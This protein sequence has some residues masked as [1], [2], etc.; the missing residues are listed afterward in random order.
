[1]R[2][3]ADLH[4]HSYLSRACSRELRPERLHAWCQLKGIGV[5]AT[6]D[7]THPKWLEELREK[8]APAEPGLYR[9]KAPLAKAADAEV[10]SACRAPVRFLLEA[11]LSCIYK[12][13]GRVRKVHNLVY[14]PS[15]QDASRIAARLEKIGN[16]RSDGRP[17]LGLDSRDLFA[18]VLECCEEAVLVPA[19]AWTPH[20]SVFGSESGFDSLEECFG[21][22]TPRVFALET[23][24]SSDPPMNW[25]VSALDRLALMSNSD[26]HSPEKLGREANRFDTEPSFAGIFDAVRSRD[27]ERFLGTLEFF[28]EE[29]KYHVDGHRACK[30]RLTPAE[31]LER[32]GLCPA[33]GKPVTVGVLHRVEKLADREEGFRP[34]GAS[35]YENLV[36]LKEILSETLDCGAATST[37][38]REYRRLLSKHGS[39]L[40]ILREL[41]LDDL[42]SEVLARALDRMRRGQVRIEAGYDG[43]YGK[44]SLRGE[45]PVPAG[46]LP[47]L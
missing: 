26:A 46:Q 12:K 1:L 38:D 10:P 7:F 47:L 41:P 30:T 23:G 8:L 11:E 6:G 39:E 37:V 2:F 29:G 3:I 16:I 31:T 45:A 28:P 25:R 42:D 35:P 9:L 4:I 18:I 22:L 40:R 14:V 27:P 15:L 17:I 5:L 33:C 21:D 43:E 20:F 13:G 19:H 32:G 34:P 44:V 36:P 24:L